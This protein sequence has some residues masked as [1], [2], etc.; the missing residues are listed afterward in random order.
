VKT[1]TRIV[2]I[3]TNFRSVLIREIRVSN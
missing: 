1:L 3:C 2:W